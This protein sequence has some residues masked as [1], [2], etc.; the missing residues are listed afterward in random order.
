MD[1]KKLAAGD[2][3]FGKILHMGANWKTTL[4]GL[5]GELLNILTIL[6]VAPYTLPTTITDV[7]PAQ[8]KATFLSVCLTSKAVVGVWTWWNTKSKNVTGGTTQQTAGGNVADPGT[9]TLVDETVKATIKSNEPVTPEQ[10]A[11]VQ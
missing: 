2:W 1:E 5:G 8:W 4:G 3:F 6:S 11:A 10:R 7:I 9:Q